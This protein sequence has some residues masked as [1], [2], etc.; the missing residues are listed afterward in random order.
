[1]LI[2]PHV[3]PDWVSDGGAKCF[4]FVDDLRV[5]LI[6]FNQRLMEFLERLDWFYGRLTSFFPDGKNVFFPHA[7]LGSPTV[8]WF[9]GLVLPTADDCFLE[10]FR[11]AL[12][13]NR[14]LFGPTASVVNRWEGW[15]SVLAEMVLRRGAVVH[16]CQPISLLS[17]PFNVAQGERE[18]ERGVVEVVGNRSRGRG[19]RLV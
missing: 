6:F 9:C 10:R 15:F 7:R 2:S 11:R 5:M 3:A 4:F 8:S 17:R 14:L 12:S 1:M 13:D 16:K 19:L 18:R